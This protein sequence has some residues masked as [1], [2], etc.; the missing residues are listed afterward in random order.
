MNIIINELNKLT[1]IFF[2]KTY[3]YI[4][5]SPMST[6][7]SIED[8]IAILNSSKS[9]NNVVVYAS[10]ACRNKPVLLNVDV[11]VVVAQ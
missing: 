8:E 4:F 1:F 10:D 3:I 5:L 2:I 6:T 11:G 9:L 7:C